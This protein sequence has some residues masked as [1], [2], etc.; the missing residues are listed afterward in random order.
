MAKELLTAKGLE[1]EL[2]QA[3]ADAAARRTRVRISDGNNL[4]LVVRDTGGASWQL[5]AWVNGK[6]KP[7]TLGR[8]PD[9]TL[10]R[11]RDLADAARD[12]VAAGTDPVEKKRLQRLDKARAEA[13]ADLTI[14]TLLNAWLEKHSGSTVYI[15]NIQAAFKKDVLPE[16][17]AM[18]P[19]AVE[20]K[21]IVAILRKMERR[22]ALVLLRRLRMWLKQMYEFALDAELATSSP[23]PTG[24]MK[25][26]MAPEEGHFAAITDP[27]EVP[28]LMRAIN[29]YEHPVVRVALLMA[30]HTFQRPTEVREAK[31]EEFDLDA[32]KWVIPESRMKKR[33]EHWVPLSP[34]VVAMLRKHQGVVGE[35][36]WL[37]PGRR[38]DQPISEGTLKAA[39]D[40][41]GYNGRHT[42]HGFRA[43]ANTILT[44]RLKADERFIEKQLSHEEENK[45]KKAYNRAEFWD[46]R[47]KLM[48]VWSEWLDAQ[49]CGPQSTP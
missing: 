48:A 31:W 21:H 34:S 18:H 19:G 38:Y 22:N 49:T 25:S 43:M 6:R 24:H 33:R 32:A 23:V 28:G 41:M 42:A 10:K 16:I 26:F 20:R 40:A 13:S 15:G 3:R 37:F 4:Q 30:A 46:D 1:Q 8:Y 47:V 35:D 5:L 11:A 45:V 17:G 39:L 27:A 2:K 14:R 7:I 36:G 29:G 44:E 12:V 9:V